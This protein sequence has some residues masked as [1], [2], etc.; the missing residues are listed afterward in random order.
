MRILT[1]NSDTF[2]GFFFSLSPLW[3]AWATLGKLLIPSVSQLP[4]YE[5][6]IIALACCKMALRRLI[7]M[8]LVC[9]ANKNLRNTIS[10]VPLLALVLV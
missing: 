7:L 10:Q 1:K 6:E 5:M 2:A 8:H 9:D 4:S 3:I